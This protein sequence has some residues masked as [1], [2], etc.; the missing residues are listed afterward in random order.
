M[1]DFEK[2]GDG[3]AIIEAGLLPDG[4]VDNEDDDRF[5]F[6]EKFW[7]GDLPKEP[8]MPLLLLL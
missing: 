5:E 2:L 4:G 8:Q 6:I 7:P 3:F 1:A